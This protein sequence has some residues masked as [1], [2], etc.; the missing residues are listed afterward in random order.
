MPSILAGACRTPPKKALPG[1]PEEC[2]IIILIYCGIIST[3]AA[4]FAS[5]SNVTVR[6][7]PT[8]T[9]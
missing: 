4:V 5:I 8:S 3:N 9:V 2:N 1:S 7:S 6:T